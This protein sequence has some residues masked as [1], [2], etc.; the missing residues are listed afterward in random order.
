VA[1]GHPV[2]IEYHGRATSKE[3]P[4]T[5]PDEEVINDVV[6]V[7]RM[8]QCLDYEIAFNVVEPWYMEGDLPY[9]G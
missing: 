2:C 7:T 5:G 4:F 8:S 9:T 6:V 3:F 1:A